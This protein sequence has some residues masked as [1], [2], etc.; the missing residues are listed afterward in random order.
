[1][2]QISVI[3]P[4]R[5]AEWF[6]RASAE[7]VLAQ[8]DVNLELIVV[9]DGST[10]R[11]ATVV[12]EIG[13]ARVRIIDGPKRGISAAFNAGLAVA[14]GEYLARCDSDDFFRPGRLARQRRWLD[15][16]PDFVAVG[17]GYSYLDARG[18]Y[19]VDRIVDDGKSDVTDELRAGVGRSHMCAYLFRTAALRLV[20]G[21]R[22]W[23]VTSEDADLQYR[24]AEFGR[25]G[26]DAFDAYGYRLHDSSITHTQKARQ[27]QW[28]AD[29]AQQFREQRRTSGADDLMRG[30]PPVFND[31]SDHA[32]A[33]EGGRDELLELM[34]GKSWEH[35]RAGRRGDAMEV[36]QRAAK[37]RPT[38]FRAWKNLALLALK[39]A[40]AS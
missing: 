35:H 17:G 37:L 9:D 16:R 24:L 18:R 39:P 7:S 21:C 5:N 8:R 20:S 1:M 32:D 33:V 4:M 29:V 27:K 11:S 12:R 38:S 14:T 36:G 28:F 30:K 31:S 10:D 2:P 15:E 13:D 40:R 23:F 34:I 19:G 25:V 3:M 22:E 26:Y 6:V